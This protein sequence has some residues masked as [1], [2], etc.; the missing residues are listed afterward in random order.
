M[1]STPA[2]LL[3]INLAYFLAVLGSGG[4]AVSAAG[5]LV[6]LGLLIAGRTSAGAR[7]L[8]RELP[9]A[10]SAAFLGT[11]LAF[12][13]PLL[14]IVRAPAIAFVEVDTRLLLVLAWLA[15][16]S[17]MLAAVHRAPSSG[18][19]TLVRRAPVLTVLFVFWSA[20]FWLTLAWDLGIG[21][22]ATGQLQADRLSDTFR[23]WETRPASEHLFLIWLSPDAFAR[24]EAYSNHL[25]PYLFL[26]YASVKLAQRFTGLP[27]AAGVNLTLFVWPVVGAAVLSTWLLRCGGLARSAPLKF[28]LTS[29]AMVGL[30]VT[31]GH[32]WKDVYLTNR[33]TI[34][35]LLACLTALV[36][37]AAL[38]RVSKRSASGVVGALTVFALF[39]PTLLPVVLAGLWC[40]VPRPGYSAAKTSDSSRTLA[41]ATLFSVV[42]GAIIYSVPLVLIAARGY[43]N[44]SSSFVFRSGLD[45]DTTYF[46]DAVQAVL[47]PYW[48]GARTVP[49]LL[50]PA[51]VPLFGCLALMVG[52]RGVAWRRWSAAF[53]F[54]IAPYL[55]S[56]VL[57]PQAVTIHPYLYDQLLF[58]PPA[59][60]AAVLALLA[61]VQRRLRGAT[62]LLAGLLMAGL[63]MSNLITIAQ[64]ARGLS[65][66]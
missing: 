65:S 63:L 41:R 6:A 36:W 4:K 26:V 11:I 8:E 30:L 39:G 50:V 23:I 13:V 29:F 21:R 16:L 2:F 57:F 9:P 47:R 43:T 31:E 17:Q 49:R 55:F 12:G 34:F 37:A 44:T 32:Y 27:M 5:A 40:C 24:G 61:P 38:P 46:H 62:L 51:Y 64:V 18:R 58:L 54:L 66:R 22:L 53:A 42:V 20:L 3:A 10:K 60:L 59:F 25:H 19:G 14:G 45:G 35:P 48:G 28:Y 15:A 33:D 7:L 52:V 1:A 56:L